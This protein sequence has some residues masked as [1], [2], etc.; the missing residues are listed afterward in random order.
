MTIPTNLCSANM[1][2]SWRVAC[3]GRSKEIAD[4]RRCRVGGVLT[5]S[6]TS[7]LTSHVSLLGY[8]LASFTT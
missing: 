3:E 1:A 5:N 2:V 8:Q 6:N 4:T 7:P